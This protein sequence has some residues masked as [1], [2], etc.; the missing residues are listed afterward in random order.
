M[1]ERKDI[2]LQIWRACNKGLN[3]Q[4]RYLLL[5]E[6]Y[7]DRHMKNYS[8][9]DSATHAKI[10]G[11]FSLVN[12]IKTVPGDI[13]EA[14]VGRGISLSTLAYAVSYLKL[15]KV[16]YGFDSF[17]G[18]PVASEKDL[19]PRVKNIRNVRGWKKTSPEMIYSIFE[20]ENKKSGERNLLSKNNVTV[21]LFP[22]FFDQTIPDHLP[23]QISLLHMDCDLYDSYRIVFQHCLPRMC[24]G[25][26]VVF[27]EYGDSRWPGATKAVDEACQ[28]YGLQLLYFEPLK[29]YMVKT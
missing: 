16:I 18:F 26:V 10:Y 14:G 25:G 4:E 22:G 5:K 15:D 28:E 29:R 11:Y 12:E 23:K 8:L 9:L 24:Q 2:L 17:N 6:A 27:D 20:S 21:R 1:E 19:G 13:V 3:H 7:D